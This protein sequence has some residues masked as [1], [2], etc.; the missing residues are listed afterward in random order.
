MVKAAGVANSW[1][2]LATSGLITQTEA[3]QLMEKERAFKD[4]RIRLHLHAGR[5][6]DRLVFDIQTAVAESL[7]LQPTGV[8]VHMR[9]ASE[10]LMQRY[11]FDSNPKSRAEVSAVTAKNTNNPLHNPFTPTAIAFPQ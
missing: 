9:R 2:T 5:R 10:Y 6:E 3:K 4:I 7:G 8:G 11:Y 1:R